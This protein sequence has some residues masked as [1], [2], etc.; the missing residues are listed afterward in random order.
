MFRQPSPSLF[1]RIRSSTRLMLWVL[2]MFVAKVGLVAA[3]S[4]HDAEKS[5]GGDRAVSISSSLFDSAQVAT[6]DPPTEDPQSPQAFQH[7]TCA[8]CSCHH[9]AA[10]LPAIATFEMVA[11]S[12]RA[13]GEL[14]GVH[15]TAPQRELRPPIS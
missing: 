15:S 10:L 3:C 8:D 11:L 5:V 13:A 7:G 9:A 2:V 12:D 6:A 14:A 4:A 1:D